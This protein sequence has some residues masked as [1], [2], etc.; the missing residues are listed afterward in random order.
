[1]H[2]ISQSVSVSRKKK[3]RTPVPFL[4]LSIKNKKL[5]IRLETEFS[6]KFSDN[7]RE[8]ERNAL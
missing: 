3:G 4:Y 1:V 2:L 6:H 7:P 5:I 8:Q